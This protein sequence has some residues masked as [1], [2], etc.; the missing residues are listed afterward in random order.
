MKCLAVTTSIFAL[1]VTGCTLPGVLIPSGDLLRDV[2]VGGVSSVPVVALTFDDGPNGCCTAAVLDALAATQTP[3]TFV[4][5]GAK[6]D[7]GAN[8]EVPARMVGEGHTIGLHGCPHDGA[9][10]DSPA[11]LRSELA[12]TMTAIQEALRRVGEATVPTIDL[13]R[14]PFGF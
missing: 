7:S 10:M 2:R 11:A 12:A 9:L 14:P 8:D 1:C 4:V 6:V 13:F 3:A 5:L